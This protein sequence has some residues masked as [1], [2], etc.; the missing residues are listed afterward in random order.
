MKYLVT[1]CAGFIGSCLTERLLKEN[2]SVVGFDN[3]S[4][5]YEPLIK[6]RNL[7]IL[8]SYY[9][10]KF[11]EFDLLKT[12][13]APFLDGIDGIFHTAGQPGVRGSWGQQFH[14]YVRN[15]IET[16]QHL[17]ETI[18]TMQKPVK[19]VYSSS[20][21]IYG[22]TDQLPVTEETLPKPYS[23]YGMTKLAAEH[24]CMV[25]MVSRRC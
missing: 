13:Y 22:N 23:P 12:D 17:L 19:V 14:L 9:G 8:N 21:S 25:L 7:E 18:K 4:D 24:L 10:F 20:S 5:Y 6:K 2:H 1:G 15:N 11:H 16:T 3:I